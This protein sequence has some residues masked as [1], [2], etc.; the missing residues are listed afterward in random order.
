MNENASLA[1]RVAERASE[2]IY[3]PGQYC[4]KYDMEAGPV[5]AHEDG[6][7]SFEVRTCTPNTDVE[8]VLVTVRPA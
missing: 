7:V 4:R 2:G 5:T 8:R 3:E 1:Q 6:T